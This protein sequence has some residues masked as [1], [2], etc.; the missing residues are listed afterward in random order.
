MFWW[1]RL[2]LSTLFKYLKVQTSSSVSITQ[3]LAP[4]EAP[5]GAEIQIS[6][7]VLAASVTLNLLHPPPLPFMIKKTGS[8][9]LFEFSHFNNTISFACIP[10]M[11]RHW[12]QTACIQS[13]NGTTDPCLYST[14]RCEFSETQKSSI[15][16]FLFYFCVCASISQNGRAKHYLSSQ[17]M[18]PHSGKITNGLPTRRRRWPVYMLFQGVII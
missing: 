13:E 8:I 2:R 17:K 14:H 10:L 5:A 3:C 6:P 12:I 4:I 18:F 11:Y 1:W 15:Y 7:H 9:C 16:I